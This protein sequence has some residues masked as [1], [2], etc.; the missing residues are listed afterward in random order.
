[1]TRMQRSH[2]ILRRRALRPGSLLGLAAAVFIIAVIPAAA[3]AA[4]PA[5]AASLS[6]ISATALTLKPGEERTVAVTLKNTGANSW[7]ASGAGFVSLYTWEPKYHA[8]A[9]A[10]SG[11]RSVKQT[12]AVAADA[13]PGQTAKLTFTV[14]APSTPGTYNEHF[15]LAAEDRAWITGGRFALSVI[16]SGTPAPVAATSPTVPAGA[17]SA[18]RLIMSDASLTLR[19]GERKEVSVLF[20]NNGTAVWNTRKL[21]LAQ[22]LRIAADG[23]ASFADPSWP[24]ET[25]ALSVADVVAPGATTF[26][27]F[28]LRAPAS[29]GQYNAS[30]KLVVDDSDVPGGTFDLPVTVTDDAPASPNSQPGPGPAPSITPVTLIPEPTIRIGAAMVP[31]KTLVLSS[32]AQLSVQTEAGL[33]LATVAQ[34]VAVTVAIGPGGAFTV[35]GASTPVSVSGKVRFLPQ[36]GDAGITSVNAG[37][38]ETWS[39]WA[40]GARFRGTVEIEYYAPADVVWVVNELPMEKYLYGLAEMSNG[41][42]H[43]YHKALITAARSYAY[44]HLTHP[45]KH[46]TFTVD[47]T[48]DQVYRAYGREAQQPNIVAAVEETRG[49][50]VHYDGTNVAT[51]YYA[52]SDGRTRSNKEVWRTDKPWLVSVEAKYDKGKTLWGHGVGMSARDAAY[53]ADLDHWTWDQIVKYYYT[54]VELRKLW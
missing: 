24:S 53:R 9:I 31:V 17:L 47:A 2:D 46:I 45:G 42:P 12:N 6:S 40:N 23:A 54:G 11:W 26:V 25:V 5:W 28:A 4:T 48:Y 38:A 43:E 52:N 33:Q 18:L 14:K 39:S 3:S 8:S 20:K 44:W 13:K 50:I 49:Q 7:R 22:G 21:A 34:G 15:Q 30:F 27:R 16:V 32:S 36:N 51:P 1:M 35:S 10:G 37:G 19:G 29:R 41:S